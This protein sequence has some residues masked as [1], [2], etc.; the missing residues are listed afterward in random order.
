MMTCLAMRRC[1]YKCWFALCTSSLRLSRCRRVCPPEC[2]LHRSTCFRSGYCLTTVRVHI[3]CWNIEHIPLP[4]IACRFG[5]L[6]DSA[7]YREEYGVSQSETVT[8]LPRFVE[9]QQA[10]HC[11]STDL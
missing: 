9:D 8:S 7:H 6:G 3:A 11:A 4:G 1:V 2:K 10:D 5:S